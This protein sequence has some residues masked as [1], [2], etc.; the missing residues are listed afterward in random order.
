[1]YKTKIT[2]KKCG[3]KNRE[4]TTESNKNELCQTTT[5]LGVSIG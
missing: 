3:V 4:P 5:V 1:M 2:T